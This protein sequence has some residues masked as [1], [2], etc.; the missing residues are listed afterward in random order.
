MLKNQRLN[1]LRNST[2]FRGIA[3]VLGAML[4]LSFAPTLVKVG[5]S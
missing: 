2:Q 5:V 3:F 1:S 4:S